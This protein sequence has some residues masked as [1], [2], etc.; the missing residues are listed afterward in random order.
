[1]SLKNS[2]ANFQDEDKFIRIPKSLTIGFRLL[3]LKN[4]NQI[5]SVY[6]FCILSF[7]INSSCRSR[8]E[9]LREWT[10]ADH[11]HPKSMETST[12]NPAIS[13]AETSESSNE[14]ADSDNNETAAISALFGVHCAKCHGSTGR[15]D[16]A[17]RP[18]GAKMPDFRESRFHASA[19]E[20]KLIDA[21]R[22]GREMMPGLGES[23]SDASLIKLIQ[24]IRGFSKTAKQK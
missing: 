12:P 14:K 20:K 10:P 7:G 22:H 6:L 11:G 19:S 8:S 13:K 15:G 1:M 16:G 9:E 2:I 24:L 3:F 4:P 18:K 23:V 21:I 5:F 17:L